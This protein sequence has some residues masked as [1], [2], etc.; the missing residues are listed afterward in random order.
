MRIAEAHPPNALFELTAGCPMKSKGPAKSVSPVSM[1]ALLIRIPLYGLLWIVLTGGR[2][3]SWLLG[4]PA[5]LMAAWISGSARPLPSGRF[6]VWHGVCFAG[7]FLK[8]S[9]ISGLDVVRRALHPRLTL[10]PDLIQYRLSLSTENARIF[11][12]DA[13]SLLPGTLS[14]DLAGVD[15]TIHVLDRNMPI[16]ADL[17]ALEVRVAAMLEAD[18]RQRSAVDGDAR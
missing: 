5:V 9:L 16:H 12:A 1:R 4:G 15:L 13:V 18:R 10:C 2:M 8:A 14:A 17:K 11:A 7:F 6:S 3:E